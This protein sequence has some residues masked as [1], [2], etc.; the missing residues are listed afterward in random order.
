[1]ENA[2][3][4]CCLCRL[5]GAEDPVSSVSQARNDVCVLIQVVI[6]GR[7]IYIYVRMLLLYLRDSLRSCYKA[8][9]AD[10]GTSAFLQHRQCVAGTSSCR[11][12]RVGND[13]Q[14]LVYILRK[15]AII[16]YRLVSLLV[17]VEADV[18]DFCHRY[19]C[20]EPGGCSPR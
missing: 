20:L 6:Y 5:L 17:A 12:H 1:M 16:N 2:A 7:Y 18:T 10:I 4:S 15:L 9:E 13:Y 19:Q 8:H 3:I 11:E 14:A